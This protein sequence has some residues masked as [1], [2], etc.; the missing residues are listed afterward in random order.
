MNGPSFLA[1][2]L[3]LPETDNTEGGETGDKDA[4]FKFKYIKWEVPIRYP[5]DCAMCKEGL[6]WDID[7]NL[8]AAKT[9]F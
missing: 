7:D 3:A 8:I 5:H 2:F 6:Q 9:K 4:E 1:Q